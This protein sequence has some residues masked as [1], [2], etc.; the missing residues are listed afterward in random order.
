MQSLH[1]LLTMVHSRFGRVFILSVLL[2]PRERSELRRDSKTA[3]RSSVKG[4]KKRVEGL[5]PLT[6]SLRS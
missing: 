4:P 3:L 5:D 1:G 6:F 2:I